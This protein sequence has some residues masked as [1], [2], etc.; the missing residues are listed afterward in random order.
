MGQQHLAGID[1][2]LDNCYG[3]LDDRFAS[4]L[5]F[6]LFITDRWCS[7]IGPSGYVHSSS[8]PASGSRT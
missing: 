3:K 8:G 5:L 6:R 4:L 1:S 7:C 2:N